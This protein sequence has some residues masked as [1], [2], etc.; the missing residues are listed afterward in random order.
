MSLINDALKRAKAAQQRHLAAAAP[1]LPLRPVDPMQQPRRSANLLLSMA[2]GVVFA[3]MAVLLW[4]G[5]Q[6]RTT[7]SQTAIPVV[8]TVLPAPATPAAAAAP[9]P[10]VPA[11]QT[12]LASQPSTSPG[13]SLPVA[14]ASEAD[15]TTP[16]VNATPVTDPPPTA[17]SPANNA[18]PATIAASAP[19]PTPLKLQGILYRPANPVAV[20][21]GKTVGVG[22][23]VGE[24]IVVSIN[25]SSTLVVVAGQTNKLS[26]PQ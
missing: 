13:T 20:I 19:Q 22:D 14:G 8:P 7:P 10:A 5:S 25:Q 16:A 4:Q 23:R 1:G 2:F 17:P 9:T 21:N 6:R 3:L 26:L 11:I 15:A 12:D 24:A 18:V